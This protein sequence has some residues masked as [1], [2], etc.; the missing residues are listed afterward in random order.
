[1]PIADETAEIP[2]AELDNLDATAEVDPEDLEVDPEVDS[3]E[4]EPEENE[5]EAAPV[6]A[7][8][9]AEQPQLSRRTIRVQKLE[10]ERD[11][12]RQREITLQARLEAL[13]AERN[14]PDERALQAAEQAKLAAMDPIERERYQSDQRIARLEATINN[15]AHNQKDA[16]D[17]VRFEQYTKH[18]VFKK[19]TADVEETL[20]GMRKAGVNSDREA[21]LKYKMGE[22]LYNRIMAQENGKPVRKQAASDRVS[23][24]RGKPANVRGDS[25]GARAGKTEEDRLRGVQI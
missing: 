19:Y 1:M 18:P 23:A 3:D 7:G 2:E 9:T 12:A 13:L 16:L 6:Q 15:L 14:R 4:D 25:N 20:N 8:A 24:V 11:E 22:A 21:I 17:K 10:K 5:D